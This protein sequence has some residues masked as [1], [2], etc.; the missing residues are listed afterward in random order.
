[1]FFL[2][3]SVFGLLGLYS[4]KF[5]QGSWLVCGSHRFAKLCG[6]SLGQESSIHGKG[7]RMS[8]YAAGASIACLTFCSTLTR[9]TSISSLKRQTQ[10]EKKNSLFFSSEVF[11][12]FCSFLHKS[13]TKFYNK[14]VIKMVFSL[15]RNYNCILI[16]M[17]WHHMD[18]SLLYLA[19]LSTSFSVGL[20]LASFLSLFCC[21]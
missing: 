2:F 17:I 3:S 9:G 21:F 10:E 7:P 14:N 6:C 12:L 19:Y 20:F 11:S 4:L 5:P 15:D 18:S 1:M 13:K 8:Y 16:K